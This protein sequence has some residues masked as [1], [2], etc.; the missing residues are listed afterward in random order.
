MRET[1]SIAI[2]RAR[3]LPA[4][5]AGGGKFAE[6]GP[7]SGSRKT[8]GQ[9]PTPV[10]NPCCPGIKTTGFV[11]S[12]DACPDPAVQAFRG[13]T[14]SSSDVAQDDGPLRGSSLAN[15]PPLPAA[16][17]SLCYAVRP[18]GEP[19][20][21]PRP[22]RAGN[23]SR[24]SNSPQFSRSVVARSESGIFAKWPRDS[25]RRG[26]A[27]RCGGLRSPS[28]CSAHSTSCP[29]RREPRQGDLSVALL[30]SAQHVQSDCGGIV[31]KACANGN[32]ARSAGRRA[33]PMVSS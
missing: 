26:D 28:G 25:S 5:R 14:A 15:R 19:I 6:C 21:P 7:R 31:R 17:G 29:M 1:R 23:F 20:G 13:R 30:H 16:S 33:G 12:H 24:Q 27:F 18:C 2:P 32:F 10:R 3:E 22:E 9:C 4:S 11:F 8:N